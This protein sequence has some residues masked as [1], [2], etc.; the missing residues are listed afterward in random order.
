MKDFRAVLKARAIGCLAMRY[1]YKAAAWLPQSKA[2]LQYP[3]PAEQT[4]WSAA[5]WLPLLL[6]KFRPAKRGLQP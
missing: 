6:D 5:A 2:A 1:D 3:E 4:F